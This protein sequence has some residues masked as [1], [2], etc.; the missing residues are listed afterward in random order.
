MNDQFSIFDEE[1]WFHPSVVIAMGKFSPDEFGEFQKR[2]NS[3]LALRGSEWLIQWARIGDVDEIHSELDTI[4]EPFYD[5]EYINDL[6]A[7]YKLI[8][9]DYLPDAGELL[10]VNLIIVCDLSSQDD[11]KYTSDLFEKLFRLLL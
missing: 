5:I 4:L 9:K 11:E 8:S 10:R 1:I 2:V 6:Y 7:D 3:R